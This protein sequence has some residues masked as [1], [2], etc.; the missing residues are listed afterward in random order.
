MSS[1]QSSVLKLL[2]EPLY[3]KLLTQ[4]L[5]FKSRKL[6]FTEHLSKSKSFLYLIGKGRDTLDKALADVDILKTNDTLCTVRLLAHTSQKEHLDTKL[7]PALHFYS[8]SDQLFTNSGV[9]LRKCIC[10]QSYDVVIVRGVTMSSVHKAIISQSGAPFRLFLG[11]SALRPFSTMT[12]ENEDVSMV[13]I[14]SS[15]KPLRS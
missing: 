11:Q 10:S 5:Q 4:T 13:D 15:I 2:W 6:S 9:R 14:F 1:F 3:L 7:F 8:D 12:I